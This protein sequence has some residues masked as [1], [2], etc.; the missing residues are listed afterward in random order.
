[1]IY[2]GIDRRGAHY[3]IPVQAKGG[4]DTLSIVQIEQDLA[5]C[6][7]KFP[8]LICRP[9]AAQFMGNDLIALF[10][11]EDSAKGVVV[12]AEQHYRLAPPEELSP[13]DIALIT[14]PF[15]GQTGTNRALWAEE[16]SILHIA[17]A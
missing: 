13:E 6:A 12:S 9:V 10:A 5:M 2:V 17:L 15:H 3:V 4:R 8:G 7:N 1:E 14:W 11:F 16:R